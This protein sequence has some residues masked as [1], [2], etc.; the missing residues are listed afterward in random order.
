APNIGA[1]F[2][3]DQHISDLGLPPGLTTAPARYAAEAPEEGRGSDPFGLSH[4]G[5]TL[6]ANT[7]RMLHALEG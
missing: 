2:R 3:Y 4:S 1:L 5:A 7:A 6:D